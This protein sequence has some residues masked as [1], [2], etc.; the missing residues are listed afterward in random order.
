MTV[1]PLGYEYYCYVKGIKVNWKR[2]KLFNGL[3]AFCWDSAI[4]LSPQVCNAPRL[5]SDD[6]VTRLGLG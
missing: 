5:L 1:R 3:S 4:A 6:D 2:C